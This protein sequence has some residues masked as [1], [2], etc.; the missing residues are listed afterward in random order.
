MAYPA[1]VRPRNLNFAFL[2][3]NTAQHS[4]FCNHSQ[5]LVIGKMNPTEEIDA[6]S[7]RFDEYLV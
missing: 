4:P 6:G 2:L 5:Y 3:L 1:K 7:K